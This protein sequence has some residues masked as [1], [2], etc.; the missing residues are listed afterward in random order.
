MN[1]AQ[2]AL[3]TLRDDSFHRVG[4]IFRTQHFRRVLCGTRRE[5]RSYASRADHTDAD[6]VFAKIFRHAAGKPEN[7][8][9]G[10]A[11]NA[12]ASES[13]LAGQRTDVDD[14][15]RATADQGRRH[16]TGNQENTL[17]IS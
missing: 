16:G 10:R 6:P 7:T 2:E 4:H 11:I 9:F 14:V 13:V 5:F 3:G 8:P 12:S 17:E 15:T 1:L